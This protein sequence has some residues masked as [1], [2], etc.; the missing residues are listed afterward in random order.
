MTAG[1]KSTGRPVCT[2][3]RCRCTMTH[4]DWQ[5]MV[6]E[7]AHALGWKHLHVRRTKGKNGWTTSTNR[8]G[9]PDL[10]FWHPRYG[11]VAIECKAASDGSGQVA[12]AR[13][14]R[15]AEVLAELHAAGAAVL[16]AYPHH[17]A[18]VQAILRPKN[19]APTQ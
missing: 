7:L 17:L 1:I 3:E 14:Q 8:E 12:E 5:D 19:L 18:E 10:F 9:W 4:A 11:F 15:Q 2:E 16:M 6:I 13:R